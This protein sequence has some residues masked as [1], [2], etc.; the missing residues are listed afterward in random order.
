M[1]LKKSICIEFIGVWGSGKTTL[2]RK[3]TEE[4]TNHGLIVANFDDFVGYSRFF[5]YSRSL[6]I[7]ITN[8]LSFCTWVYTL[9]KFF[10]ILKPTD[11]F[12]F[13][14]YMTMARV[15]LA[16]I[17][18]IKH[19]KPDVLLW[20][21]EYHLLPMF[22]KMDQ[23]SVGDILSIINISKQYSNL[24]PVF[25][26]VDRGL[27]EKRIKQDCANGLRSEND[28]DSLNLRYADMVN[29][30]DT[31]EQIFHSKAISSVSINGYRKTDTNSDDLKELIIYY[32]NHI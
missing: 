22:N 7:F 8:P 15:K 28:L 30:Q 13:E 19:I 18:L 5:R 17:V 20:E 2:V 24:L 21:G 3:V 9:L 1:S 27:A 23:L 32:M 6:L 14:I 31:I 12:Q 26:H 25:I 16:K 4:L 29:N 10:V 11:R